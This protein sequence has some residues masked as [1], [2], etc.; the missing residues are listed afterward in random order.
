MTTLRLD[1]WL[2]KNRLQRPKFPQVPLNQRKELL[3]R[4][5]PNETISSHTSHQSCRRLVT[6]EREGQHGRESLPT[7]KEKSIAV[8]KDHSHQD[9]KFPCEETDCNPP[10]PRILVG[11]LTPLWR[12][13]PWW[14]SA[15]AG[16]VEEWRGRLSLQWRPK[17][18]NQMEEKPNH[19]FEHIVGCSDD[20]AMLP[21]WF[22]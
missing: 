10:E 15:L 20:I 3:L 4:Q 22:G 7:K 16:A 17:E 12:L 9:D 6:L 11:L 1:C 21:A 2:L 19:F 8:P 13:K 5:L 18:A 14:R